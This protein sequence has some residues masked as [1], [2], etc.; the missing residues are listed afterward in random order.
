M[1]NR[2]RSQRGPFVLEDTSLLILVGRT[3][4]DGSSLS[5]VTTIGTVKVEGSRREVDEIL[6]LLHHFNGSVPYDEL[7]SSVALP[8]NEVNLLVR[9]LLQ[10]G[11]V[12][13]ARYT[14]EYFHRQ[15]RN[16][17]PVPMLE[18]MEAAYQ[19]DPWTPQGIPEGVSVDENLVQS[20]DRLTE[21]RRSA[22]F[23]LR[24]INHAQSRDAALAL[25]L[26]ACGSQAVG[27][28][29]TASAGALYPV[30]LA[31]LAR[32][33]DSAA[34]EVLWID[35]HRRSVLRGRDISLYEFRSL[36]VPDPSILE[37]VDAGAAAIVIALDPVR[38]TMKYGNRGWRYCLMEA[39]A[40]MHH[41]TLAAAELAVQCRPVGGF[42]DDEV[43]GALN[44]EL[45][46]QLILIIGAP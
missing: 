6:S 23:T 5:I 20:L 7:A 46:A 39:G 21:R 35:S 45:L 10:V 37:A 19:E 22:D 15:S 31:V 18:S 11:A 34:H 27:R 17:A 33:Y 26:A 14:W 30:Q 1:S 41:L 36:F 12:F 38:T 32:T 24:P 44:S 13:D 9:Q 8:R 42:Y 40:V 4:L 16:P 29:C 2:F 28:W 25:A 3:V 43:S